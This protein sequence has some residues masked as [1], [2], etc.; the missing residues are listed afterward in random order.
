MEIC[1]VLI[2]E[3][4]NRKAKQ[5][6]SWRWLCCHIMTWNI[7]EKTSSFSPLNSFCTHC[8]KD[9]KHTDY[10]HYLEHQLWGIPLRSLTGTQMDLSRLE[11]RLGKI[12]TGQ[13]WSSDM[14]SFFPQVKRTTTLLARRQLATKT[15]LLR[16]YVLTTNQHSNSMHAL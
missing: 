1:S 3:K 4:R 13:I 14:S 12:H 8:P 11:M 10:Y 15:E 6:G 9:R 2:W 5:G 7:T 16:Y